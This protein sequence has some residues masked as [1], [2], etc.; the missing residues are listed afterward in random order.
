MTYDEHSNTPATLLFKTYHQ[1]RMR[2]NEI[3]LHFS[4]FEVNKKTKHNNY[5]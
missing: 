3:Y 2:A 4:I 1:P 5:F